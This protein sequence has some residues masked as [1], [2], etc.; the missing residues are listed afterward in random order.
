MLRG[1]EERS[2]KAPIIVGIGVGR[3]CRV[4]SAENTGT[5]ASTLRRSSGDIVSPR[6]SH[7]GRPPR[8]HTW[9]GRQYQPDDPN[10]LQNVARRT[11]ARG[12]R[13][14]ST[15]QAGWKT[16]FPWMHCEK[17]T[18][19]IAL[20]GGRC[21]T[22]LDCEECV[23]C[24][25]C[26]RMYCK[27]CR[28]RTG[29]A[30]RADVG[31]SAFKRDE[32]AR[33]ERIFHPK[34]LGSGSVQTMLGNE[35][36]RVKQTRI[37]TIL[38]VVFL[39]G[40]L[41]A[42]AAASAGPYAHARARPRAFECV[43]GSAA[44]LRCVDGGGACGCSGRPT[45]SS[46]RSARR[47]ACARACVCAHANPARVARASVGLAAPGRADRRGADQAHD[48]VF[49]RPGAVVVMVY[50]YRCADK[51]RRFRPAVRRCAAIRC[52]ADVFG[53]GCGAAPLLC[54]FVFVFVRLMRCSVCAFVCVLLCVC[55]FAPQGLRADL[56][57][58]RVLRARAD[59]RGATAL[60]ARARCS[61]P[62]ALRSLAVVFVC[63]R[64]SRGLNPILRQPGLRPAFGSAKVLGSMVR[65]QCAR[66]LP[67][68]SSAVPEQS[69]RSA[70]C[71][72][73][74]VC[75]LPPGSS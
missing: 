8:A 60:A 34:K 63:L 29:N 33:H 59:D 49:L 61:H 2:Y 19:L 72:C 24:R 67:P 69:A 57:A 20:T 41:C 44:R 51:A 70:P 25:L 50:P 53:F 55:L 1:Q 37:R 6:P 5:S 21:R 10:A 31:C 17:D 35:A 39:A 4:L 22:T 15:L 38:A 74:C 65:W 12:G 14:F 52:A 40:S 66:R 36:A 71:V 64:H 3:C 16:D 18:E 26:S 45:C 46:R 56:Q 54:V 23:G 73:L 75:L 13:G 43:C 68:W 42:F 58:A 11:H 47:C 9:N 62:P 28:S 32:L 48:L 7:A 27:H 30:F